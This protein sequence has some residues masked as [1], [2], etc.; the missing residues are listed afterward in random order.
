MELGNSKG[1]Q[2]VHLVKAK[3]VMGKIR[4]EGNVSMLEHRFI[5]I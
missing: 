1:V 5:L 2:H 4:V 3:K